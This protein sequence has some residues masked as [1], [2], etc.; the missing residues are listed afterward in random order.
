L[1]VAKSV[2][3]RALIGNRDR[4]KIRLLA[5]VCGEAFLNPRNLVV[6]SAALQRP[7]QRS[8]SHVIIH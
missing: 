1:I 6:D 4:S 5:E 2:G 8:R 3:L 7:S